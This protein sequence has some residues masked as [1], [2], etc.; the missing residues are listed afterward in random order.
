MEGTATPVDG[1]META[2]YLLNK[3]DSCK[4]ILINHYQ[5][6][7]PSPAETLK[8]IINELNNEDFTERIKEIHKQLDIIELRDTKDEL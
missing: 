8:E 1:M 5:M 6:E 2:R 4:T 7:N 3:V